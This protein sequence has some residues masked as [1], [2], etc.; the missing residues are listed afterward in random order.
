VTLS[1]FNVVQY[2]SHPCHSRAHAKPP[3]S[4]H[5]RTI[6]PYT[7]SSQLIFADFTFT[8][9][10]HASTAGQ[11]AR[12]IVCNP[13]T[14]YCSMV[15]LRSQSVKPGNRVSHRPAPPSKRLPKAGASRVVKR[16]LRGHRGFLRLQNGALDVTP[17]SKDE[18][19][20]LVTLF[21]MLQTAAIEW[22]ADN[23]QI[24]T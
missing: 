1:T 8:F 16:R 12:S 20:M 11:R 13:P 18:E 14:P 4:L 7:V 2:N 10:C 17:K 22:F 6:C 3:A 23:D 24:R 5:T 15:R 21:V 19:E 9:G